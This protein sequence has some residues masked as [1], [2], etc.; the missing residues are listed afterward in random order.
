MYVVKA[1]PL[2]EDHGRKHDHLIDIL[3]EHDKTKTK[4]LS[5]SGKRVGHIW[6]VSDMKET[7]KLE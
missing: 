4:H 3:C 7:I 1:Q 6:W 2:T 5:E